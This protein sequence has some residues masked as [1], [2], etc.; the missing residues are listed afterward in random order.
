MQMYGKF[1]FKQPDK[2]TIFPKNLV[3]ICKLQHFSAPLVL[4]LHYFV[5]LIKDAQYVY[6]K[7][8][9]REMA[10]PHSA[11]DGANRAGADKCSSP[12]DVRGC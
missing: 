10:Q 4:L 9:H 3:A 1:L 12:M 2:K 6:S 8:I 11:G 7:K 5:Y